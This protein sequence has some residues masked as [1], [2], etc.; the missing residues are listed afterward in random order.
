MTG[1]SDAVVVSGLTKEFGA[2]RAL[3]GI[4]FRVS[5]GEIFALLGPNGAGKT[6][7]M[8]ILLTLLRP[9][10]GVARVA[11]FDV[12][13]REN[14]VFMA[15]LHHLRPKAARARVAELLQFAGLA[16]HANRLA[17]DLSGGMRRKLELAMGLVHLPE[18]LFL[19]EPTL[20][21]DIG[22]RRSLW[23]Y[24]RDIRAAGT[25]VLLTTHYL[26]EADALCDRVAI[27]DHGLIKACDTPAAL[28]AAHGASSLDDVFLA[29]TGQD[30]L[31]QPAADELVTS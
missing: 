13:A 15:G 16:G 28:K 30:I 8:R 24:V 5:P 11:G 4:S 12:T 1:R 6:T 2:T 21:L 7:V 31:G 9:T 3:D 10:A 26:E 18:V 19:D 20:G 22:A 23:T 17:A 25:T 29:A 14:L 27:I